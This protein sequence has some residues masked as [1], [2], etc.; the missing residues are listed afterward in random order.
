MVSEITQKALF[1]IIK[2]CFIENRVIDRMVSVIGVKFACNQ[3][4]N[5]IH[6]HIA[7]YF[8]NLSDKI[9][10]LCLERYN[11]SVVYGETPSA[12][13]DYNSLTQIIEMLEKRVKDFQTMFMG[14]CKIAYENNDINVYADLMDLL[15]QYNFI[16][17]QVILLNDKIHN[18]KENN[19]MSFDHDIKDFWI[20]N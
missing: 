13:G 8:P 16:V 9:G 17:E 10:E 4:S 11:I 18:Y 6:H 3:T 7:H 20:L 1:D 2:Q 5:L 19:I 12:Y 15:R 14:L